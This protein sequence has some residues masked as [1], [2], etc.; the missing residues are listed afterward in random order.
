M[1]QATQIQSAEAVAVEPGMRQGRELMRAV[2]PFTEE[3]RARSWWCLGSTVTLMIGSMVAAGALPWWPLQFLMVPVAALLMVRAFILFHD[4]MHGAILQDSKLARAI[5]YFVGAMVMVPPRSWRYS[6][7]YHHAHV[8]QLEASSVGS[9]PLMTVAKWRSAS[10]MQRLGYRL[11]RNPL[12]IALA[13]ATVFFWSVCFESFLREP[14][15]YWDSL[16]VILFQAALMTSVGMFFGWQT[17]LLS[18]VVPEAVAAVVGAYL[19]YAQHNCEG[20]KIIP[21][22]DWTPDQAALQSSS[23]MRLSP[24]MHWFTGNIGYHHIH[25]LNPAVP[26]YR[27]PEAMASVPELQAPVVTTLSFRDVIHSLRLKLWDEASQ[28]M[29]TFREAAMLPHA[30]A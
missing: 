5:L 16:V 18:V 1:K 22:A 19:F 28:R 13:S 20:L 29:V 4:F 7:N 24:V 10:A 14:K 30:T 17:L 21:D 9:F 23:F 6:H 3:Q 26:F 27:L 11:A 15:R 25:H 12:V 8:G 2:M